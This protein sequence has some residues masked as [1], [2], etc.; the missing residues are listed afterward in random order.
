MAEGLGSHTGT[1]RRVLALPGLLVV[2]A[3]LAVALT[4]LLAPARIFVLPV[5]DGEVVPSPRAAFDSGWLA[6]FSLQAAYTLAVLAVE[7]PLGLLV[8]LSLPRRGVWAAL[9][10]AMVA[11]PLLLPE[12]VFELVRTELAPR[13]VDAADSVLGGGLARSSVHADVSTWFGFFLVDV[14]RWT[15]LVILLCAFAVRRDGRLAHAARLDRLPAPQR[16]RYVHWPAAAGALGVATALR[17]ADTFSAWPTSGRGVALATWVRTRVDEGPAASA[18]LAVG[19][20]LLVLLF[21]PMPVA[22]DRQEGR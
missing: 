17:V 14:W 5:P 7:L 15:P 16:V 2:T 22:T 3:L 12:P 19:V 9:S 1:A 11:S 8:A 20:T 21:V 13:L 6:A 18:A 10:V 4:G